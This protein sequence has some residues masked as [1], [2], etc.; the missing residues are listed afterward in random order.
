MNNVSSNRKVFCP[1][2]FTALLCSG[3][4]HG[5]DYDSLPEFEIG[6]F[7][8]A[9]LGGEF[10][11]PSDSS[12][13][14]VNDAASLGFTLDLEAGEPGSYYEL[15]YS[16]QS[17][18]VQG[19]PELDLDIQY[20]H[21]GGRVDYLSENHRAIPF[22]ALGIGATLLS[23]DR[24]GFQDE[25]DFSLSLAGGVK[26]PLTARIGLR[27]EGRAL[28]TFL[29]SDSDVFCVSTPAVGGACNI[30]NSSDTFFQFTAGIGIVAGF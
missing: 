26:I 27:L 16:F 17:T 14:D 11:D 19:T 13:R 30:R 25:T 29:N 22:A 12:E 8:G 18:D 20:V 10:E 1:A 21:I 7:V 4:A 9:T 3:A 28:L 23:P 2:L 6:S 24:P 5:Q 15:F